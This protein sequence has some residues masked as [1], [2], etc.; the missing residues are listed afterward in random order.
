[1]PSQ[2][3]LQGQWEEVSQRLLDHWYEISEQL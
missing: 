2:K 3:H 1:M